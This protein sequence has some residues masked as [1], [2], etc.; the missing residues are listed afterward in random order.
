MF[1]SVGSLGRY[2]QARMNGKSDFSPIA[3][4]NEANAIMASRCSEHAMFE[5]GCNVTDAIMRRIARPHTGNVHYSWK[6]LAAGGGVFML[7]LLA[8]ISIDITVGDISINAV[9]AGNGDG[10][11]GN[12]G[13]NGGP[14]GQIPGNRENRGKPGDGD[15]DADDDG[16][17]NDDNPTDDDDPTDGDGSNYVPEESGSGTGVDESS[18]MADADAG[19]AIETA[20]G[21]P[22]E[23]AMAGAPVTTPTVSQIFALG[24]ESV[25]SGEAELELIANGWKATN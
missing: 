7:A 11:Y 2:N 23:G 4:T 8:P 22:E 20:T 19:D 15:D 10:N 17:A 1:G 24:N 3:V 6:S 21:S 14:N 25:I 9:Q 12:G 13:G 5:T 18:D 16:P